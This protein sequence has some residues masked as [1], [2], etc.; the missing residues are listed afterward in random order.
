[1]LAHATEQKKQETQAYDDRHYLTLLDDTVDD[2]SIG[3]NKQPAKAPSDVETLDY[4]IRHPVDLTLHSRQDSDHDE[5][6]HVFEKDLS[7]ENTTGV[8]EDDKLLSHCASVG[9][10]PR[11]SRTTPVV[12]SSASNSSHQTSSAG[13]AF[14]EIN[15][16][17]ILPSSHDDEEH[18]DNSS[19][20]AS[21]SAVPPPNAAVSASAGYRAPEDSKPAMSSLKT[22]GSAATEEAVDDWAAV[23]EKPSKPAT[24]HRAPTSF[25]KGFAV[26]DEL[27]AS[28]SGGGTLTTA[29]KVWGKIVMAIERDYNILINRT[30]TSS[31]MS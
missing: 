20:S 3:F 11:G 22:T 25:G 28:L 5:L 29:F 30:I 8:I 21:R 24:D 12:I 4:E 27:S 16:R 18:T 23:P 10:G 13:S 19:T 26:M 31:I 9:D 7:E 1:M 6:G 2:E 14:I 17:M 15:S